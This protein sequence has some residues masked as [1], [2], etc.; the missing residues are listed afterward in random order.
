[1]QTAV[2]LKLLLLLTVAN[3]AP[4]VA[5]RL[6]GSRLSYPLDGRA[7]FLDGRPLFGASKT[8]RGLVLSI[9]TTSG[10]APLLGLDLSTGFLVGAGAMAGDLLSS[11]T[12]RRLGLKPSSRATGL[13]QIPES[14]LPALLCWQE[15]SLTVADG[16]AVVGGFLI[17]EIILSRWL[18]RM[19]IRDRPY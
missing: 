2:V 5:K 15:L 1:M 13:D 19:H 11:F 16:V 6:L 7:R 9:A 10:V 18:F 4:V 3:G 12:K 8:I 14:L 17:G